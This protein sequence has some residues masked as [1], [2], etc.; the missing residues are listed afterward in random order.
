MN[1]NMDTIISN[2]LENIMGTDI[3]NQNQF[4]K[5]K[6]EQER[7]LALKSGLDLKLSI[8]NTLANQEMN[9]IEMSRLRE[10]G[11][12]I[13]VENLDKEDMLFILSKVKDTSLKNV[14]EEGNLLPLFFFIEMH[15]KNEHILTNIIEVVDNDLV[16]T[17]TN[18]LTELEEILGVDS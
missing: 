6:A 18:V 13:H 2:F 15:H 1:K 14:Y 16:A 11:F 5:K 8:E 7:A 4:N 17:L 3:E 9:T 10:A 12:D